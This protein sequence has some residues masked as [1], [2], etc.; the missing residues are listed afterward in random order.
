MASRISEIRQA[1][2]DHINENG[3]TPFKYNDKNKDSND[4]NDASV[5]IHISLSNDNIDEKDVDMEDER[6]SKDKEDFVYEDTNAVLF[7][8]ER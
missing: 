5:D 7:A 8:E 2:L 4:E 6:E 3:D 1:H